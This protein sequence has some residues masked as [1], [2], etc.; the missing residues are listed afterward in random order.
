MNKMDFTS[1]VLEDFDRIYMYTMLGFAYY[2]DNV[3]E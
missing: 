2:G 3:T 1:V